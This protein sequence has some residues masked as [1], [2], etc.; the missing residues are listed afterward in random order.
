[1]KIDPIPGFVVRCRPWIVVILY[2]WTAGPGRPLLPLAGGP[3]WG[4]SRAMDEIAD[5]LI[6]GAGPAGAT[7][8][9]AAL[10]ARPGAGVRLLDAADFPRDKACGDGIAAHALHELA[11]LGVP[12]LT[13][14]Y[15]P[16]PQIELRTPGG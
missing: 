13:T 7:A 12:D 10:R 2:E 5:V 14:G 6:V 3:G 16:V 1:M 15:R 8:A 4:E 11:G 9:L